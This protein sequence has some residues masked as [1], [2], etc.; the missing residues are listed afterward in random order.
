VAATATLFHTISADDWQRGGRD[1]LRPVDE[2]F[3]GAGEEEPLS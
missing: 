3:T 2:P 1:S